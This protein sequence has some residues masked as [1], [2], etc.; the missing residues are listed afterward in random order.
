MTAAITGAQRTI[1]LAYE[2]IEFTWY[3]VPNNFLFNRYGRAPHIDAG[4][5]CVNS[6]DWN[7]YAAGTLLFEGWRYEPVMAPVTPS[8]VNDPTIANTEQST[9]PRMWNVVFSFKYFDPPRDPLM[10]SDTV[11]YPP[12]FK[13]R[14]HNLAPNVSKNLTLAGG[15]P[16]QIY[17]YPVIV[18]AIPTASPYTGYSFETLFTAVDLS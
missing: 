10:V 7:G 17:W 5:S 13:N 4:L 12:T 18:A 1:P 14:G 16:T 6:V 9:L 8:L 3:S 15:V 2:S 11:T